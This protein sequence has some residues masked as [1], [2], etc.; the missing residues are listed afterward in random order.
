M[1]RVASLVR[2]VA[3]LVGLVNAVLLWNRVEIARLTHQ[4]LVVGQNEQVSPR[5]PVR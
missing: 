2:R 1:H 4:D 5:K 3:R